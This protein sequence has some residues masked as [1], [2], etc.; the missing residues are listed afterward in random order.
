MRPYIYVSN[1]QQWNPPSIIKTIKH[2][3]L[4]N[5]DTTWHV[6]L[7]HIFFSFLFF[8]FFGGETG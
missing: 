8:F 6:S 3:L 1:L 7:I 5:N 4:F 2:Q